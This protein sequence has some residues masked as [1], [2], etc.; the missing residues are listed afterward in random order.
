ML[1]VI[2]SCNIVVAACLAGCLS[3]QRVRH[4]SVRQ[5]TTPAGHDEGRLATNH[6]AA[7]GERGYHTTQS[8]HPHHIH[9]PESKDFRYGRCCQ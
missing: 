9:N 7:T 5:A 1:E 3:N 6:D 2:E 8:Y 4:L